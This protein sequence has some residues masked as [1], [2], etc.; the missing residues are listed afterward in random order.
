ML[1]IIFTVLVLL[2]LLRVIRIAVVAAWGFFKVLLFIVFFPGVLIS[3][4]FAGMAVFALPLLLIGG[5]IAL[6]TP[7]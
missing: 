4:A 7:A 3:L 2:F 1:E 5:T 6:L